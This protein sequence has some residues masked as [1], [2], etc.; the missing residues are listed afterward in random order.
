MLIRFVISLW[1]IRLRPGLTFKV[2]A[3]S[4]NREY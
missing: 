2:F 4:G 1:P 3:Q